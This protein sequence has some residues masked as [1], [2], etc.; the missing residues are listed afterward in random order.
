MCHLKST[1]VD[2]QCSCFFVLMYDVLL[3]VALGLM[4][5]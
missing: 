4:Y 1:K 5:K 3:S 2:L